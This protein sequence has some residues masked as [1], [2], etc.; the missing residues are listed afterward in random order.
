MEEVELFKDSEKTEYDPL[1]SDLPMTKE[2]LTEYEKER[3]VELGP[4]ATSRSVEEV[5]ALVRGGLADLVRSDARFTIQTALDEELV[6]TVEQMQEEQ[7]DPVEALIQISEQLHQNDFLSSFVDPVFTATVLK[8]DNPVLKKNLFDRLA[9]LAALNDMIVKKFEEADAPWWRDINFADQ[10]LSEA[11]T[12]DNIPKVDKRRKGA[13][14][15]ALLLETSP[16]IEH[17]V[18]EAGK[19]IDEIGDEG[20]LT[21]NNRF[22]LERLFSMMEYGGNDRE[23]R[24]DSALA[25]LDTAL[26]VIPAAGIATKVTA[27]AATKL[28]RS[29]S[30]LRAL[31]RISMDVSALR[32]AIGS[33]PASV[34]SS[35]SAAAARDTPNVAVALSPDA[36]VFM[37]MSGRS[38][39]LTAPEHQALRLIEEENG[40]L[41]AVLRGTNAELINTEEFKL[42]R[43]AFLRDARTT[44]ASSGNKRV[45]DLDVNL[46]SMQNIMYVEVF[47]T[48]KG[49]YFSR[50]AYAKALADDIGGVVRKVGDNAWQVEKHMPLP[51]VGDE[52][53][54]LEA[55]KLFPTTNVD[56]LGW[57]VWAKYGSPSAQTTE[58][59]NALLKQG[60]AVRARILDAADK[61]FYKT[62]RKVKK[63]EKKTV[64]TIW[65][66]VNS[67]MFAAHRDP[68]NATVF[69]QLVWKKFNR[70]ATEGEVAYHL[71]LQKRNDVAYFLLADREFKN[72]VSQGKMVFKGRSGDYLVKPTDKTGVPDD[73][74]VYNVDTK[75]FVNQK[76]LGD[77]QVVYALTDETF[78]TP[79]GKRAAFITGSGVK[80]RR[81]YH[82]DVL[83]YN[84]GGS[85]YYT[86]PLKGFV[87]QNRKVTLASG[88][89][90]YESPITIMGDRQIELTKKAVE[91][92]NNIVAVIVKKIPK[93]LGSRTA[94]RKAVSSLSGDAALLRVIQDN[95]GWFPAIRTVDDLVDFAEKSGLDLSRKVAFAKDGDLVENLNYVP[96][97]SN[98][99]TIGETFMINGIQR[100]ARKNT[101][102]MKYGG[103]LNE[104]QPA[105]K[106]ARRAFSNEIAQRTNAAYM[107]QAAAGL[108]RAVVENEAEVL[109]IRGGGL[110]TFRDEMRGRTLISKLRALDQFV[111]RD[112]LLGKKLMLER[113]KILFRLNRKPAYREAIDSWLTDMADK[114]Y[115][116]GWNKLGR[117]FDMYSGDPIDAM[118]AYTFR[119][120]LGTFAYDQ[121]WVQG[122]Q[123]FNIALLA[124]QHGVKGAALYAPTRF[125]LING[126]ES[127]L[128][129]VAERIAPHVGMSPD[130]YMEAV[131]MLKEDGRLITGLSISE[132]GEESALIGGRLNRLWSKADFFFNEGELAAR[133]SAHMAAYLELKAGFPGLSPVSQKGRRWIA[134]R[135][136]VLTQ[137]MTSASRSG[138]S[139]LPFAQFLTYQWH[140]GESMLVGSFGG[141]KKILTKA[142]KIR[143]LAGHSVLYGLSGIPFAGVA[144]ERIRQRYG[145]EV[146]E[147]THHLIRRGLLDQIVSA[148]VG[149]RTALA[150]RIAWG[151]SIWDSLEHFSDGDFLEVMAG[152]SGSLSTD[153]LSRVFKTLQSVYT[154]EPE[155]I[156]QDLTLLA[157]Q[158]KSLDMV[159]QLYLA[160]TIGD[161]ISRNN[162]VI[163]R[164]VDISEMVAAAFGF[165]IQEYTDA[166]SLRSMQ[167]RDVERARKIAKRLDEMTVTAVQYLENEDYEAYDTIYRQIALILQSQ[168]PTMHQDVLRF[169]KDGSAEIIGD[170]WLMALERDYVGAN[171]IN[172]PEEVE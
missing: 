22:Y 159:T 73:D 171:L 59:L 78:K 76:N 132:L 46:D 38:F 164:D 64:E 135:Q 129:E 163:K 56:E 137:H 110:K 29:L 107:G 90:I 43:E 15:L 79:S 148:A 19:I 130:D 96:G 150:D 109:T 61:D 45:I 102:L 121:Y 2:T 37:P 144:Y 9:K 116:K 91:E 155:L 97:V 82:S 126:N 66:E 99:K 122:S 11:W 123:I 115:G 152:P 158:V 136:D 80:T 108:L 53:N 36:S 118:K 105:I 168:N 77:R 87:K 94:V 74:L 62:Y 93:G 127:V 48:S 98:K 28:T 111:S 8:G 88:R 120:F 84:P 112:T 75:R 27:S 100:G 12:I 89:E 25:V 165:P 92:I 5:N 133:I 72:A 104:I 95:T 16:T 1:G 140:F 58:T 17:F 125:A 131:R 103:E 141:S 114:F 67:G 54:I 3:M 146:P 143:M 154:M 33:S 119:S 50:E 63:Q 47:G 86:V 55:F 6:H 160:V 49:S 161:H 153:V 40:I 170:T 162:V 157:R 65:Q 69:R 24:L 52:G 41:R 134:N 32:G 57:G 149:T 71:A 128:K 34:A 106:S 101:Q 156:L 42:F 23:G 142:E 7:V 51:L 81:I 85:R 21:Q 44:L 35:L 4:D 139:Q 10:M 14:E 26:T 60:E 166:Y 13:A 31:S 20:L 151:E 70:I 147:G 39:Y 83:S 172:Q 117:G 30:S 145:V 124:K 138:W 18:T 113:D 169:W 167:Y 68:V